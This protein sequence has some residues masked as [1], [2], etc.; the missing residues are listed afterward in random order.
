MAEISEAAKNAEPANDA[1]NMTTTAG[2]EERAA[3][4]IRIDEPAPYSEGD[5]SQRLHSA[6]AGKENVKPENGG[7]VQ[8]PKDETRKGL[9]PVKKE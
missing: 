8:A 4:R 3:K 6:L 1:S 9:A 2:E 7:N 5:P